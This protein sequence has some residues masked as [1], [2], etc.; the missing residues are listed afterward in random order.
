[1]FAAIAILSLGSCAVSHD[2]TIAIFTSA[3]AKVVVEKD[4]IVAGK[5]CAKEVTVRR[6]EKELLLTVIGKASQRQVTIYPRDATALFT[7]RDDPRRYRYPRR[8]FMDVNDTA[9][10]YSRNYGSY[11]WEHK[12][13]VREEMVSPSRKGNTYIQLGL[14][15][16]NSFMMQPDSENDHKAEHT[17]C[18]GYTLGVD[19]FYA[20]KRYLGCAYSNV[21]DL[22]AIVEYFGRVER[23]NS[24]YLRVTHGYRL[25]IFD[26]GYGL[27]VAR[28]TWSVHYEHEPNPGPPITKNNYA[29]GAAF[30]LYIHTGPAF[31]MGM[32]Y[33]PTWLRFS[34]EAA[35]KYEYVVSAE[36]GWKIKW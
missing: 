26:L 16:V 13:H 25:G 31:Y 19:H 17:G 20:P 8:V 32:V 24:K 10:N 33:R 29:I 28:N 21:N 6:S 27:T 36:I 1:M 5:R 14:P 30:P 11:L 2:C 7:S 23:M 3:P 4:T 35:W 12:E 22:I 34:T 15:H 18:W 9:D